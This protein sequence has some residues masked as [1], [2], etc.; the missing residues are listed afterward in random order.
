[1][2]HDE[3]TLSG[4]QQSPTQS[5]R[6][7]LREM[8]AA[9]ASLSKRLEAKAET[10]EEGEEDRA[11]KDDRS[12]GFPLRVERPTS[13]SFEEFDQALRDLV[14]LGELHSAAITTGGRSA[15]VRKWVAH[16]ALK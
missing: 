3:A 12:P 2:S 8:H 4:M 13:L 6:A 11:V 9:S 7:L 10:H 16:S 14:G 15:I 1:V 5:G